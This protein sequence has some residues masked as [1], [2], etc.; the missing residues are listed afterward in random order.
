MQIERATLPAERRPTRAFC[1]LEC[2][3][4]SGMCLAFYMMLTRAE[5]DEICRRYGRGAQPV[6]WH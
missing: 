3:G 5:Q 1:A 6:T 2:D 4:C